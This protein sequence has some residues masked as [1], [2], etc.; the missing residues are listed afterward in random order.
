MEKHSSQ[1]NTV[2]LAEPDRELAETVRRALEREGIGVRAARDGASALEIAAGEQPDLILLEVELGNLSGTEVCRRLKSDS[3][4]FKIPVV[5][6]TGRDSETDRVVGFELGA[7][8]YVPKPF[9]TR[10]LTLRVRAIL[11]RLEPRSDDGEILVGAV[12]VDVPRFEATVAGRPV[13]MTRQEFRLLVA[14]TR[15]EGRVFTRGELLDAVWGSD[16]EV[17]ERTV[18]AHIKGLRAKLGGSGRL[19]ETVHGVGYRVRGNDSD[20]PSPTRRT[21]S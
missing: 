10:E 9:S 21:G 19:I 4:T 1:V 17:L 16:A 3:R 7:T 20:Y 14:L 13:S 2:L 5:F 18:D 6:V 11:R 15:G 8:D 12:R